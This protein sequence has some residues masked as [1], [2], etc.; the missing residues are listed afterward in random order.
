M[1][2]RELSRLVHNYTNLFGLDEAVGVSS[3]VARTEGPTVSRCA[4]RGV[5]ETVARGPKDPHSKHPR[6]S[7]LN[8]NSFPGLRA[9][10]CSLSALHAST[11][12]THCRNCE[13]QYQDAK[14]QR[15]TQRFFAMSPAFW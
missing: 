12:P 5:Q 2:Q 11:D 6:R 10:T 4:V 9:G 14:T 8:R 7:F 13:Q 3:I 15:N 1:P